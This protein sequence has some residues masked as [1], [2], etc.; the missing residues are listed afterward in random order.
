[1]FKV[2]K[3]RQFTFLSVNLVIANY[4]KN[5]FVSGDNQE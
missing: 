5:I 1:M 4:L 3:Y 2:L